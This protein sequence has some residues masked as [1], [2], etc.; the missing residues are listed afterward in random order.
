MS[1]SY[2]V[3]DLMELSGK[4]TSKGGKGCASWLVMMEFEHLKLYSGGGDVDA[5]WVGWWW[6]G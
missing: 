3:D 2:G 1:G 5:S 6:K 4:G